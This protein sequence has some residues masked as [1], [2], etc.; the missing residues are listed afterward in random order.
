[1]LAG[2]LLLLLP[3]A[4]DSG[5]ERLGCHSGSLSPCIIPRPAPGQSSD[6][7]SACSE[8]SIPPHSHGRPPPEGQ[9]LLKSRSDSLPNPVTSFI[10]ASPAFPVMEFFAHPFFLGS[11][12]GLSVLHRWKEASLSAERRC[13]AG[14]ALRSVIV[15]RQGSGTQTSRHHKTFLQGIFSDRS[16]LLL[17]DFKTWSFLSTKAHHD[18]SS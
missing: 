9:E 13:Q 11:G 5:A 8:L 10:N 15:R 16:L 18:H 4:T 7:S 6:Y 2:L 1:M 14:E 17:Y 12:G 3:D